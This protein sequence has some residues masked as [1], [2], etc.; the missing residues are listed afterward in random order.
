MLGLEHNGT[1][2]PKNAF[3]CATQGTLSRGL[4]SVSEYVWGEQG[5]GVPAKAYSLPREPGQEPSFF[6]VVV[7]WHLSLPGMTLPRVLD[8][9]AS[10][11]L[12]AQG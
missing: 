10:C 6:P 2:V 12:Q 4:E 3:E 8:A 7:S 1:L 5:R 11:I 9:L